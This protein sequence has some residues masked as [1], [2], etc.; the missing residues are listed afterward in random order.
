MQYYEGEIAFI[1][2]ICCFLFPVSALAAGRAS[3][4]WN[5]Y[6]SGYGAYA[7]VSATYVKDTFENKGSVSAYARV[8]GQDA[9]YFDKDRKGQIRILN[10]AGKELASDNF[11]YGKPGSISEK[12]P[13]TNYVRVEITL[14]GEPQNHTVNLN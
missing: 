9:E 11:W 1:V 6:A 13:R 7:N 10:P 3:D 4:S 2:C 8:L 12:I 5:V 14:D